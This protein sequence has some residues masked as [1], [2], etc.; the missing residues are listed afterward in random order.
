LNFSIG[1]DI[2]ANSLQLNQ[3]GYISIADSGGLTIN[4]GPYGQITAQSFSAQSG[5]IKVEDGTNTAPT[6]SSGLFAGNVRITG[7]FI[8][9]SL[10]VDSIKTSGGV[11]ASSFYGNGSRLTNILVSAL[12]A[13]TITIG[14]TPIG[15]GNTA[16]SLSGL[17]SISASTISLSSS[18]TAT[19]ASVSGKINA[20]SVV[21]TQVTGGGMD[22]IYSGTVTSTS[23]SVLI[24]NIFSSSYA[25]YRVLFTTTSSGSNTNIYF[26]YANAGVASS[27]ALYNYHMLSNAT[28]TATSNSGSVIYHSVGAY[29]TGAT[30][31]FEFYGPALTTTHM[32][33]MEIYDSYLSGPTQ[34]TVRGSYT[35]SSSFSGIVLATVLTGV[36]FNGTVRVYGYHN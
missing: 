26:K 33:R 25:N 18:I 31:T 36:T 16:T 9:N 28:S 35:N 30:H 4:V 27:S 7:Q 1:P 8:T 6:P 11:T 14:S 19:S 20:A 10:D 5:D 34:Q 24:D 23:G 15:L 22:L 2:S 3:D 12:S 17:N 32:Y 21:A 29:A 13:S